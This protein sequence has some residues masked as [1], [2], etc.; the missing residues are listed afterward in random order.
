[1][2]FGTLAL[3]VICHKVSSPS[4]FFW[5]LNFFWATILQLK[6]TKRQIFEK[7]SL[8]HCNDFTT[9]NYFDIADL[10]SEVAGHLSH[11]NSV[12]MTLLS[13]SSHN[14]VNRAPARCSRGHGFNS[15]RRL[16]IFFAP[17]ITINSFINMYTPL[18]KCL[19]SDSGKL[20]LVVLG[21]R[22]SLS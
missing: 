21:E 10:S 20:R 2:R 18:N 13:M 8:E 5:R 16:R 4:V 19:T 14:S 1:M 9:R 11:M 17:L 15:C 3:L 7:V 22:A 6:V 12:K